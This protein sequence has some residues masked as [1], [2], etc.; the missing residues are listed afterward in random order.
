MI[1]GGLGFIEMELLGIF[2]GGGFTVNPPTDPITP[3]DPRFL[4]T[5]GGERITTEAGTPI[6]LD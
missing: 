3:P 6:E 4:L 1:R 2:G 5:E